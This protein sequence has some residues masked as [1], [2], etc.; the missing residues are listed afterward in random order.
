ML[1]PSGLLSKSYVTYFGKNW[2]K[3]LKK[4][5]QPFITGISF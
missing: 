3:K 2:K 1:I 4:Y 5:I